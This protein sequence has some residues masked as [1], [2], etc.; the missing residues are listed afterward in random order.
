MAVAGGVLLGMRT[1]NGPAKAAARLAGLALIGLGIGPI[2]GDLVRRAGDQRR[3][4]AYRSSLVVDRP[5]HEVFAFL[6]DFEN[7]PRVFDGLRSVVDFEDGRSHWEAYT[8]SGDVLV[9]DVVITKYVPNSVIAWRTVPRSVVELAG[10]IRFTPL[11]SARTRLDIDTS[12][13]PMHTD[14]GDAV[15]ALM[16]PSA[17]ERVRSGLEHL[18]FYV[19]SLPRIKART[20]ADEAADRVS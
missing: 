11:T 1:R 19:E 10:V 5:V 16:S 13:R 3:R 9:W 15:R 20:D 14:L 6:K 17:E 18:R 8:P 7:L 4:I 12:F 2:V